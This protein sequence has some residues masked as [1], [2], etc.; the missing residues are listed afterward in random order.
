MSLIFIPGCPVT[1]RRIFR[2][3]RSRLSVRKGQGVS[4]DVSQIELI[5]LVVLTG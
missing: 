4:S 3:L 1:Y 2:H 5:M